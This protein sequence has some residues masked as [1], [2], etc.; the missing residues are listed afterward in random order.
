MKEVH[1]YQNEDGTFR[2]EI[3]RSVSSIKNVGHQEIKQDVIS[4]AEIPRASIHITAYE[5]TTPNSALM[6]IEIRE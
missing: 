6:T 1:A 2:V 4:R 5:H 3:I